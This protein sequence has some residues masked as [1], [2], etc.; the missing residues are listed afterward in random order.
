MIS[1]IKQQIHKCSGRN[2]RVEIVIKKILLL[3]LSVSFLISCTSQETVNSQESFQSDE[4]VISA[5]STPVYERNDQILTYDEI[6]LWASDAATYLIQKQSDVPM[7]QNDQGVF[8]DYGH[9]QV[10]WNLPEGYAPQILQMDITQ[11]NLACPRGV[12]LGNPT[13][14]V[15]AYYSVDIDYPQTEKNSFYLEEIQRLN[16]PMCLYGYS[17]N[18]NL[19]FGA[20]SQQQDDDYDQLEIV[21][22]ITENAVSKIEYHRELSITEQELRLTLDK[23]N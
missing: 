10:L 6:L 16:H 18:D 9:A 14:K 12:F 20:F 13:A 1:A 5:P 8:A 22:S 21:F 15:L 23:I 19:V 7:E 2:D 11:P 4:S 17:E 3:A